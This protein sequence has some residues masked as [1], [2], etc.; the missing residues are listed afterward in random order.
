MA[1]N[2]YNNYQKAVGEQL[3]QGFDKLKGLN[4]DQLKQKRYDAFKTA[5]AAS[6]QR[7]LAADPNASKALDPFAKS[8]ML[9]AP[10]KIA[11]DNWTD[12]HTN[13]DDYAAAADRRRTKGQAPGAGSA[14]VSYTNPGTGDIASPTAPT[15]RKT[16]KR[17]SATPGTMY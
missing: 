5:Q 7:N 3:Q 1:T 10:N 17:Q 16:T 4:P 9:N 6:Q 8:E 14:T 12:L 2:F 13:M 15:L 11:L